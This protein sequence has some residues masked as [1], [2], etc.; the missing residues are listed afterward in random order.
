MKVALSGGGEGWL[1]RAEVGLKVSRGGRVCVELG[2]KEALTL[3]AIEGG[4]EGTGSS[5]GD[6]V[7]L[8]AKGTLK[9]SVCPGVQ[10][11]MVLAN[12]NAAAQN[13]VL[14]RVSGVPDGVFLKPV[15]ELRFEPG[16]E[17]EYAFEAYCLNFEKD[18]PSGSDRFLVEGTAP[19]AVLKILS[20]PGSSIEGRQ[21]AIWA[22]T[23]NISTKDA[24][25]KFQS[26]D[27]DLAAARAILQSAGLTADRYRLF[28]GR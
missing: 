27:A 14:A 8:K 21:L 25:D 13:M 16:V 4:F 6:S 17:A 18:N 26:T 2:L 20:A 1:P 12:A 7:T 22:V 15:T 11:G 23:D 19:E 9:F 5:S 10:P 28:S 3:G 24:R